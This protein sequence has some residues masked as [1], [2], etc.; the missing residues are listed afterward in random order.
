VEEDRGGGRQLHYPCVQ[1]CREREVARVSVAR[2]PVR[3]AV[4]AGGDGRRKK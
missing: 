1:I 3:A 4:G 2:G